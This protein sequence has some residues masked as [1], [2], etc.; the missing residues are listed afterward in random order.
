[1]PTSFVTDVNSPAIPAANVLN[2]PGADTIVNNANGIQTD[3]SSGSNTLTIQLTNRTRVTATTSDGAGQTQTVNI[4]TPTAA[5][6]MTFV[7]AI[8]GYDSANNEMAGGELVGIAR[9][10]GG[11]VVVVIGTNDT[12]TET[13]AGLMTTDYDVVTNGVMIQMQFVGVAGRTINWSAVFI[14]DQVQ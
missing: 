4:F 1:V 10:S 2:V 7:V 8:T 14:Y 13:D 3:G 6:A 12:F 5:S 11:G 9:V